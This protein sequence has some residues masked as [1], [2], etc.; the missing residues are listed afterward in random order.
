[1]GTE[2]ASVDA[3]VAWLKGHDGPGI[4]FAKGLDEQLRSEEELRQRAIRATNVHF[5]KYRVRD[6]LLQKEVLGNN[7]D[8]VY[9]IVVPDDARDLQQA[10]IKF[11][12]EA[13]QHPGGVTTYDFP[14]PP[15]SNLSATG[16]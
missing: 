2:P 12:H 14:P 9:A 16:T 10:R 15:S 5:P 4:A 8:H 11:Y 6:G 7:A 13:A 1:M 3:L